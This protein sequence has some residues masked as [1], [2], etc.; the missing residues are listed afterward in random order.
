[1]IFVNFKKVKIGEEAEGLAKICREIALATKIKIFPIALPIDVAKIAELGIEVW[2]QAEFAIGA[3]GVLLNHSDYKLSIKEIEMGIK[4]FPSLVCCESIEE[5][6]Q[7]AAFNPAY[8][9][10]EPPELI[11]GDISVSSA[12]PEIIADFVKEIKDI[13]ILVGAGIHNQGDVR[14]AIELGVRGILVSH[15]VVAAPDPKAVL[16]DLAKG[17]LNE[18][19]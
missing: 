15:G 16:L 12:K 5:G 13:P 9:A 11:G 6:K 4:K 14:K 18:A 1:M 2:S 19:I 3:A 8:L 10:Y 17:Y 7:I